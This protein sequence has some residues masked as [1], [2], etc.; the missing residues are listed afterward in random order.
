MEINVQNEITRALNKR[1]DK[2]IEE[3]DI[4]LTYQEFFFFW[5]LRAC[6]NATEV[7]INEKIEKAKRDGWID[8]EWLKTSASKH[9]KMEFYFSWDKVFDW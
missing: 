4:T 8:G 5:V 1:I 9:N 6:S 2:K 7:D 3:D